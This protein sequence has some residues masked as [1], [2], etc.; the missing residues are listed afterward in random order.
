MEKL[1]EQATRGKLRFESSKGPLTTEQ[2]WEVPLIAKVGTF[3]LDEVAK[4]AKRELDA[5]TEESFVE[6]KVNAAKVTAELKLEVVKYIISVRV[7]EVAAANKRKERAEL[8]KQLTEALAEK[9]VDAIK[10]M[11]VE[12]IQRKLDELDD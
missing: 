12:E 8:R 2:L 11:S 1:F 9:Q 4:A 10:G 6:T 5:A 7:A 3:S